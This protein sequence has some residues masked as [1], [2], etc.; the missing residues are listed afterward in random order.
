MNREKKLRLPPR[1]KDILWHGGKSILCILQLLVASV[2]ALSG[3]EAMARANLDTLGNPVYLLIML[4]AQLILFYMIWHYYDENDDRSFDAFCVPEETPNLLRDPAYRL[5]LALTALGGGGCFLLSLFPLARLALPRLPAAIPGAIAAVL[6]IAIT[7]ASSLLRL[8]RLNYVWSVQKNLRSPNDKRIKPLKRILYTVIFG[9]A[10]LFLSVFLTSVVPYLVYLFLSLIFLSKGFL[11]AVICLV[12]AWLAFMFLRRIVD[13]RKFFK[14]LERLRDRGELSF[15]VH[16]SP[17]LSLFI[18]RVE[19][20]MTIVDEPHR[21]SHNQS[22]TTYQ[23]AI[24]NCNRRRLHVVLCD[25]NRFQFMF[26]FSLRVLGNVS[27]LGIGSKLLSIPI[28]AFFITHD[29]SFPEG[30]GKRILLVDPAPHQLSMRGFR[31]GEFIPL[32]NASELYGY[33]VYGKNAF[34]RVLER[35]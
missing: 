30:E 21:E 7:G 27:T 19:F 3:V 26:G 23:V 4:A 6:A 18:R 5:G 9:G 29:F 16:G 33:T 12:A 32:D 25:D 22:V 15:T 11:I 17:Y 35:S 34:V 28:G 1:A 20:S 2:M 8:R 14:R 31:E 10:I 24:A 13:R